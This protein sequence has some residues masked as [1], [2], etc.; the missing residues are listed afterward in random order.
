MA[1]VAQ[2]MQTAPPSVP[3]GRERQA[4]SSWRMTA[5]AYLLLLVLGYLLLTPVVTWGSD[6]S[7][8][9]AIASRAPLSSTA[10]SGT[11]R[12]AASRRI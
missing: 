4:R 6:D 8:T 12:M 9:C 10:S 1:A 5:L 3:A 11:A 7:T 2:P